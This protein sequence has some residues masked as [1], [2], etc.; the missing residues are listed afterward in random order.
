[1]S[2]AP[3]NRVTNP[4]RQHTEQ[5]GMF[6]TGCTDLLPTFRGLSKPEIPLSV[7]GAKVCTGGET[8][9]ESD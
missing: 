1:M 5:L 7:P 8:W 4:G 9:E 3:S 6:H 2:P